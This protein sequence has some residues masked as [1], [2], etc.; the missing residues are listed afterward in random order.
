MF[1]LSPHWVL[2]Y[3]RC[4][5]VVWPSS[6]APCTC[7]ST[8]P[9]LHYHIA[10][11]CNELTVGNLACRW[12]ASADAAPSTPQRTQ[13]RRPLPPQPT[14]SAWNHGRKFPAGCWWSSCLC[15]LE[16]HSDA[17]RPVCVFD[18]ASPSSWCCR[19]RRRLPRRRGRCQPTTCS[20]TPNAGLRR[21]IFQIPSMC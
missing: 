16:W 21:G 19:F 7:L 13:A 14:R 4:A 10:L 9:L 1:V 11:C 18:R 6:F 15:I 8:P 20:G 12:E 17:D 5:C 2:M 3:E